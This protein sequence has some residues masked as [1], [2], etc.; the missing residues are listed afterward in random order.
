M[1]N[2]DLDELDKLWSDNTKDWQVVTG[3][4][5]NA[6]PR[7]AS[8]L[9]RLTAENARMRSA[10]EDII[11]ND[12]WTGGLTSGEYLA[13]NVAIARRALAGG[14]EASDDRTE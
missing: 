5:R 7:L 11:Q 10:L 9:R 14:E 8:E 4:I 6:Y 12:V 13:M 3:A 2:F 1:S